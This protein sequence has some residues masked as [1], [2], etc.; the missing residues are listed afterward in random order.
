[1]FAALNSCHVVLDVSKS[2]SRSSGSFQI[3]FDKVKVQKRQNDTLYIGS[4]V[5]TTVTDCRVSFLRANLIETAPP[6]VEILQQG[7]S[8]A[9]SELR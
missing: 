8:Q 1:V 5:G 2:K 7:N 4:S 3:F 6:T 9:K